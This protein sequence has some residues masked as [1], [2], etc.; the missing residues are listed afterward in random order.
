MWL[1]INKHFNQ[2]SAEFLIPQ[3][4]TASLTS[5]QIQGAIFTVEKTYVSMWLKTNK[6]F[7]PAK[8]RLFV[9]IR[10]K[11]HARSFKNVQ[12]KTPLF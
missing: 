8:H 12:K 2:R 3:K 7:K 4:Y 6:H 1:K 10:K 9:E 11:L 5:R